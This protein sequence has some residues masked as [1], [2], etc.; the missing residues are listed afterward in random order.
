MNRDRK[1]G[2]RIRMVSSP[3]SKLYGVLRFKYDNI[4]STLSSKIAE[5]LKE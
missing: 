4:L 2:W 1:G 3:S 5:L